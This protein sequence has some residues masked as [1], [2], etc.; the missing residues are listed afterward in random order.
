VSRQRRPLAGAID[1]K[2][3]TRILGATCSFVFTGC[4]HSQLA[5]RQ[6][7]IGRLEGAHPFNAPK[8][9]AKAKIYSRPTIERTMRRSGTIT[10]VAGAPGAAN[11]PRR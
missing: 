5:S 8:L 1:V 10:N 4:T 7:Q 2:R 6:A 11:R 9:M 3:I